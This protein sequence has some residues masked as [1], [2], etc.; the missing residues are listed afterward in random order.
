MQQ[1]A[2]ALMPSMLLT[3]LS[4]IQALALELLW[5]RLTASEHLWRF[6]WVALLG[7]LQMS[8]V[9]F[10]IIE[11]WLMYTS[12]VLRLRWTPSTRDS[13]IPFV[14]GLLEFA[15]IDLM[16]PETMSMWFVAL[17]LTFA[18]AVY[19]TQMSF[20]R[21]R[22]DPDNRE[23]FDT[24]AP[25]SARDL[26]PTLGVVAAFLAAALA[27]HGLGSDGWAAF[28]GLSLANAALIQQI[29]LTRYYTNRSL[30]GAGD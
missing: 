19:A 4:I 7:W 23:F 22:R 13:V 5:S 15:M 16:G 21:A 17:A 20:R 2:K 26:Y 1:R 28:A 9:L 29:A 24:V 3:L 8:A 10:G 18:V 12:L 25:V 27:V 30:F 6:D 14:I 11:I